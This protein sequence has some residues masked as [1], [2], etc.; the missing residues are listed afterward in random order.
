MNILVRE[1]MESIRSDLA[2]GRPL[3][4]AWLFMGSPIAAEIMA[5]GAFDFLILDTEHAPGDNTTLYHQIRACDAS[6]MPVVVRLATAD[7]SKIM[8][9]LDAGASGI[10]VADV[11]GANEVHAFVASS[12][13]APAGRRGTHRMARAAGYGL[14]WTRYVGEIAPE[15]VKIAFIESPEGVENAPDI[16]SVE[17]LDA[18]FIGAVDLAACYGKLDEP[19]HPDI[20]NAKRVV[21]KSAADAGVALGGLAPNATAA[22]QMFDDGY[23]IATVGSDLA[24][25]R[26]GVAATIATKRKE[27]AQ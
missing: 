14:D 17:G 11:R 9:A 15:L 2:A 12:C 10:A 4:G 16:C 22:A 26:E 7:H 3:S 13:Y 23:A 19:D 18:V 5:Q 6:G 20:V 1:R 8:H 25:L 24:W 21:A 27:V